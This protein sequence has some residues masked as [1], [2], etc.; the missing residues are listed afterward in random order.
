MIPRVVHYC[1]FSGEPFPSS[2]EACLAS[3]RAFLPDFSFRLWD[4][5]SLCCLDSAY[6]NEALDNRMWAFASDYVR[7]YALY[8]YGGV[9]LDTDVQLYQPLTPLLQ[10]AA[11]IGKE[12]SIHFNG[13]LSSQYLTSHCFGAEKEHPFVKDCLD[14][15][16]GQ[17]FVRSTNERLPISL[18]FNTLLLP[19][20]QSEIARMFGFDDR[21]SVQD[22][23]YCNNGLVVY[24]SLYFDAPFVTDMSICRHLA[25]GSWRDRKSSEPN[26][27][28]RYKIEWRMISLLKRILRRYHY[29]L[30]K[31]D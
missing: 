29:V 7:L 20:I 27:N 16:D 10:H 1:W 5:D 25:L 15:F 6:L 12:N 23:Q 4:K 19:F 8:H 9:Y 3:W 26:Y 31:T 28:F 13:R 11:F 17:H 14:Y 18:R 30:C 2:V 24:P 21:P 22:V